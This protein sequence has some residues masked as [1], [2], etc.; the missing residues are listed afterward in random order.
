[1]CGILL[2]AETLGAAQHC[3]CDG[4]PDSAAEPANG[5]TSRPP[6][7]DAAAATAAA[8]AV[9]R[10][11]PAPAEPPAEF[12][13]GL[14]QRGPDLMGACS[15]TIASDATGSS[16]DSGSAPGANDGGES[17]P[18]HAAA[19][20]LLAASL[21]QLRGAAR[22]ARCPLVAPATGAVLCFNG[23]LFGGLAVPGG[24]NDG[25]ALLAALE[26]AEPGAVPRVLSALRGP[27][28]LAY[29]RPQEQRLWFGRD[30]LGEGAGKRGKGPRAGV[31]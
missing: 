12:A 2:I 31:C 30:W 3:A 11:A 25:E 1:M 14:R 8:A 24:A 21:L 23:E 20:L 15:V 22:V 28:A 13:A 17:G 18:P 26:A 4:R 29:W 16:D 5:S 7:H 9:C 6:A 19:R 27:W 10:A